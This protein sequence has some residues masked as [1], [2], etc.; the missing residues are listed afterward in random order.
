MDIGNSIVYR[1][2]I[3]SSSTKEV[4]LTDRATSGSVVIDAVK[5]GTKDFFTAAQTDGTLG[6]LAFLHGSAAGNKVQLTSTKADLGD[7]SYGDS[8]GILTMEIPY[9]LV[10]SAAGNDEFS[11]IYT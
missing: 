11:L 4:L 6:N 1:E 3:G 8:D 10:P 9:T 5:P 2:V 7:I